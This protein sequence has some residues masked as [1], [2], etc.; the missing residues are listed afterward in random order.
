MTVLTTLPGM[1]FYTGNW[2]GEKI[3]KGGAVYK[4]RHG[5][6]LETQFFPNAIN[7]DGFASP[8]FGEKEDYRAETIYRFG[9]R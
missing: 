4:D 1:Q 2:I 8:V 3:G 7:Q 5:F 9:V 6:C